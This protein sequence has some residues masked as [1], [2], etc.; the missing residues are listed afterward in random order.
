MAS[1]EALGYGYVTVGDHVLGADTSVRPDWK[2]P[3][4]RASSYAIGAIACMWLLER[5]LL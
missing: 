2:Q 4:I 1:L 5:V 3:A